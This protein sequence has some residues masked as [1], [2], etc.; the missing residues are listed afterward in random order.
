MCNLSLWLAVSS[1]NTKPSG[2]L[3]I[4]LPV[5]ISL[6]KKSGCGVFTLELDGSVTLATGISV[7]NNSLPV[8]ASITNGNE[9]KLYIAGVPMQGNVIKSLTEIQLSILYPVDGAIFTG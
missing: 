1:V 9:M 8:T 3:F 4:K 5:P 2:D 6:G 7:P